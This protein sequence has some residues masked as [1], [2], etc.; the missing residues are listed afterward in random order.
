MTTEQILFEEKQYL[1]YNKFSIIRRMVLSLFCF[2]GYY[3]SQNPKPVTVSGIEIG[4]YPADH[5][6]NSGELFFLVGVIILIFSV[7][8]IFVLHLHTQLTSSN[9]L[10]IGLWTKRMVKINLSDLREARVVKLKRLTF[11]QPVYNLHYRG[12][13]R[14]YTSGNHALE[15]KD[16][17]GLMYRIG[18]H[19]PYE[20]LEKLK[21][22]CPELKSL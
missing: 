15:L 2:F 8:L 20:L 22:L 21:G 6:P 19:K 3:W 14:F 1:G 17:D 11:K 12:K 18:T 9:L 10:L 4:S 5:I 7:I 16:K 13:I